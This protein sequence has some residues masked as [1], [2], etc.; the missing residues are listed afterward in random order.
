[1]FSIS[2]S[3]LEEVPHYYVFRYFPCFFVPVFSFEIL[4]FKRGPPRDAGNAGRVVAAPAATPCA[5]AADRKLGATTWLRP[6]PLEPSGIYR[7]F[8]V[9]VVWMKCWKCFDQLLT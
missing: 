1:M 6:G 4:S 7:P 2:F 5:S 3:G 8:E 9:L